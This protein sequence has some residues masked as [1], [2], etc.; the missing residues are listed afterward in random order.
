MEPMG[1]NRVL[2]QNINLDTYYHPDYGNVKLN[3]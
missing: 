1:N 3:P 2:S